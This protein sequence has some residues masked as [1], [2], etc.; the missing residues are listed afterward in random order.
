MKD[1]RGGSAKCCIDGITSGR[2]SRDA[3]KS[4]KNLT[5]EIT[6]GAEKRGRRMC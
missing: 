6:E 4:K 3:E 1:F 5:T 2:E